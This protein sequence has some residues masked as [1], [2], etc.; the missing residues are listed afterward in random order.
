MTGPE[1]TFMSAS[2]KSW[3]KARRRRLQ[4]RLL[5]ALGYW[6]LWAICATLRLRVVDP[7]GQVAAWQA[8]GGGPQVLVFWHDQL[9]AMPWLYRKLR[10]RRPASVM[11]SR[12]LSGE[13]IAS[14]AKR[15][16]VDA[17]RGSPSKG[18][19]EACRELVQVLESGGLAGITPDGSRGPR[20]V[21]KPGV[22]VLA[23]AAKAQVVLLRIAYGWKVCL[24]TW[25]RFQVPLPFSAVRVEVLP[26]VAWDDPA[27]EAKVAAALGE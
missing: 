17:A 10:L 3:F 8:G 15:F 24:P 13:V 21:L 12:N 23:K 11:I 20:H 2:F 6:P 19:R 7:S 18:G 22:F 9:F 1:A 4:S 25:D 26:P 16:G 5:P 14:I 27:L